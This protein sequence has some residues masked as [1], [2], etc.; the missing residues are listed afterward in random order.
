MRKIYIQ[1]FLRNS[2]LRLLDTISPVVV[3]LLCSLNSNKNF[4]MQPKFTRKKLRF[5]GM[6]AIAMAMLLVFI[7]QGSFAQETD[8]SQVRL[9]QQQ[10][11]ELL[12]QANDAGVPAPVNLPSG[13]SYTVTK[14]GVTQ[15]TEAV[16]Q[17]VNGTLQA[18]DP[19]LPG[20]RPFRDGVL[21]T[22]CAN[23]TCTAGIAGAGSFYDVINFTNT[24]ATS[25]CVTLTYTMTAITGGTFTFLSVHQ[26]TFNPNNTC[27]NYLSDCGGSPALNTPVTFSFTLAGNATAAIV[28]S[29]VGPITSA[30]YTL[31]IDG[32]CAP[33]VP[34]NATAPVISSVPS[35]TCA[36]SPI[37]LS[38]IGGSLNG[39][40][41]W[42]WYT[43]SCGGT[44]VGTGPFITVSPAATTTY[45]VRGEGGCAPA[46]G[47][48]G[49]QTVTVTS[50]TCLTP[51][52]ATICEG[53][54]QRLQVTP[55][56]AT[57]STF[58]SAV[59]ITIPGTGTGPGNANP[60]PGVVAV[61]GLP[62]SGAGVYV[63][64][65]QINGFSHTWPADIDMVLVSPSGTATILMSDAG[66]ST[67]VVNA[68]IVFSDAGAN[69]PA[70]ITSGTYKLINTAGPDNFPA[71]GPGNITNINPTLASFSPTGDPN[72]NWNLY[73]RDQAGGDAGSITSWSITFSIVPT[74]V[75][76]QNP[77]SPNSMFTN[78][79]ATI[80]Y[81]AG[82]ERDVIWVKPAVTTTYT[83]TVSSGPCTGANNVTVTVLPRPTISVSPNPGGCAPVTLTA[84]GGTVYTWSPGTGL[85]TTSG[86][87]V[88]A[89]PPSNTTY[90]VLGYGAN[91]CSNTTTVAVNG[92]SIAAVITAPPAF[93]T[94]LSEGFDIATPLPSGWAQQNLSTPIGT[95]PNW[96]Q[97]TTP[98]PAQTGSATSY[99]CTNFNA[100]GGANTISNWLFTPQVTVQNGD[101]LT[102]YARSINAGFPDRL[103]VRM[104]T[105]GASVNAGATN[106]S[107]GDFSTLLLDINPT[108][109]ASG[110]PNVWTLHTITMSGLPGPVTGRFAFRY[111]VENGGPAGAN[112]DYIGVDQVEV[113]RPLSGV[114]ANTVSNISVNITGGVAPFTL[115]YTNGTTNTT[116]NNYV[117]GAPIQVSPSVTTTYTIVS[118]TGANG[119]P[120]VNNSGSAI[121]VVTP[122]PAITAQPANASVCSG[123]NTTFTVT[124]TPATGNT[125]QWQ[126]STNG[127]GSYSNLAN[128]GN[129]SGVTT[130]T[131]TVTG[132][133]TAMSG[134]RYR[135]LVTGQCPPSPVTSTGAILTVN[136]PPTITTH[137]ASIT[138]CV[139]TTATFSVTATGNSPTYQWQVSTDGGL[140][141][142][143]ISGATAATLSLSGV[144]QSMNGYRYRVVVTVA[145]CATTATSNAAT[146]SVNALPVVTLTSPDLEIT[147]GQT[148][149]I[150]ASSTP[151]A[152]TYSW[153]LNGTA[154][155]G[156]TSST[157]TV[158]I[159]GLGSYVATVTDVNGCTASSNALVIG[160]EQS[161]RLWIY[162][163]PTDGQFQVRLY[164]PGNPTERRVITIYNSKGQRITEK[165]FT[166]DNVNGPYL[167]MDF[168]LRQFGSGT[169]VVR[170]ID[171]F[172]SDKPVASGLVV[173]Q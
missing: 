108:Y 151:A 114:C 79:A 155:T 77:A 15:R 76:T 134:Y 87:T 122:P 116:Y 113:K 121:I 71:P 17:T 32:V 147:P 11:T 69:F 63:Q 10:Q 171:R 139:G 59:P 126:I 72:G 70:V 26:G 162:P 30:N 144:T 112:S 91:G 54:T 42:K 90:T 67:D 100:V 153:T 74:A 107:T 98:F 18:G 83:A 145:P 169:Y 28:V 105:N 135:V 46:P 93:T 8:K 75:W 31:V 95:N 21:P 136:V 101:Q 35:S 56:G 39:A 92:T 96:I 73:I 85:N 7:A 138:R 143:N 80:P 152:A 23:K 150:T 97:G 47:P 9:Q 86:A 41:D 43:A 2:S 68:N 19:T 142:T 172:Q 61:S 167:R 84:S 1:A 131:L 161:D 146:L 89:T 164:N 65:V 119:C 124:T 38:V 81:V 3:L 159:D 168:D 163:N 34:N 149:T 173:I 170:V 128:G 27:E 6:R 62:A 64:S 160:G 48:C 60:Y 5:F 88:V 165:Q 36:G 78:T 110:F 127:G 57:T 103:Q 115:V 166:L 137:P 51:D 120:G 125:Y 49:Q 14:G 129:Y 40:A 29:S 157:V 99:I 55:T 16:C 82:T 132:A 117:S 12:R 44:L 102:F 158:N 33:C 111:F 106:T 104:S 25:Q 4:T 154:I 37:T 156:A 130:A 109:T 52:V 133:T 50:C 24:Q 58:S 140:T 94:L 148:T 20:N 22:T 53:S 45:Y 141:Y 13:V 123:G 118:V 66:G